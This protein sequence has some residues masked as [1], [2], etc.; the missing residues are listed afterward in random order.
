MASFNSFTFLGNVAADPETRYTPQ[1]APV[2]TFPVAVNSRR[3]GED[4]KPIERVDYFRI[5]TRFK[6]A[7][8]CGKYLSKGRP[9]FVTGEV[10]TWKNK[11]KFGINFLADNVQFIGSSKS[12]EL[13]AQPG[14]DG[15]VSGPVDFAG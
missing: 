6:L 9:V 3:K 4:G 7:E 5:T 12:S 10:E 13:V 14:V 1:G 11:E 2:C 8:T 15:Q